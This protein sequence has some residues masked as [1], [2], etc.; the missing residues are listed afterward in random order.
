M[1]GIRKEKTVAVSPVERL[2]LRLFRKLRAAR[3]PGF[4]AVHR[5]TPGAED[6]GV[7]KKRFPAKCFMQEGRMRQSCTAQGHVCG[8]DSL[9]CCAS[10]RGVQ[11]DSA[12]GC[13][14]KRRLLRTAGKIGSVSHEICRAAGAHGRGLPFRRRRCYHEETPER[15]TLSFEGGRQWKKKLPKIMICS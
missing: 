5:A 4:E 14:E 12:A 15:V 2:V 11:P 6:G 1:R 13:R 10:V 7:F 3:K 9:Q 8:C